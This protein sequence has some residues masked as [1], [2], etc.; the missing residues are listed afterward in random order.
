MPVDPL[1]HLLDENQPAPPPLV[2][3]YIDVVEAS[4]QWSDWRATLAT[5]MYNEWKTNRGQENMA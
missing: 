1:E 4:D 5:Q 3:E 2:D